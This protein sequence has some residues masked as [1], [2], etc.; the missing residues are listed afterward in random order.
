M[1]VKTKMNQ[2]KKRYWIIPY[3]LLGIYMLFVNISYAQWS[4]PTAITSD[5]NTDL[6][7][8]MTVAMGGRTYVAFQSNRT[9][10]GTPG[11]NNIWVTYWDGSAWSAD[12]KVSILNLEDTY[13]DMT[14]DAYDQP[15]VV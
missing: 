15:W 5:T 6:N 2:E 13:P 9:P 1:E 12:E 11:D 3:L 7:P 4:T 10:T 14:T 8:A